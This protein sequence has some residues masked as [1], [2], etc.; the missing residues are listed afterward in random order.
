MFEIFFA[1]GERVLGGSGVVRSLIANFPSEVLLEGGVLLFGVGGGPAEAFLRVSGVGVDW[2]AFGGWEQWLLRLRVS[3][4]L[5][6]AT[7]RLSS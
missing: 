4:Q 3:R 6:L 5:G 7:L 1:T 2:G